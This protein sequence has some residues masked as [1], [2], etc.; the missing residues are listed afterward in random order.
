[1]T[2][3]KSISINNKTKRKKEIDLH[4]MIDTKIKKSISKEIEVPATITLS[5]N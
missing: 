4:Q 5:K 2:D 3:K 1:M